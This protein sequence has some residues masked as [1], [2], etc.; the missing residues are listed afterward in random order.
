MNV[1]IRL[2][3]DLLNLLF[4]RLCNACGQNLVL[5]ERNI[6]ISCLHD[7]PFTD[8]HLHADNRAAKQLWGR[9]PC[10]AVMAMLYFKKGSRVQRLLHRLKYNGQIELGIELGQLLGRRLCEANSFS[11]IDI[12]IPVP[13]HKRRE[14]LRGYNQSKCIA[15]GIAEHLGIPVLTK[16][17]IKPLSTASQTRKGRFSRYENLKSV[18][19]VIDV[20]SIR[21]KHVLLV[22]D[23]ITTGATLEACGLVL[24]AAGI[25][26]LSIA[27]VAFTD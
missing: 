17:L 13:L 19:Q 10:N 16:V 1:L 23:V 5:G 8:Y 3:T 24:L 18:F 27:A 4:P 15:D 20:Q 12:I 11:G 6:C 25:S 2:A 21:D 22:D 9:L 26:N 14:R 7:L